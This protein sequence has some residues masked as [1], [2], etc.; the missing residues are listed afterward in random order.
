MTALDIPNLPL[1]LNVLRARP[2]VFQV[3]L[4]GVT[5]YLISCEIVGD[6]A[7]PFGLCHLFFISSLKMGCFLVEGKYLEGRPVEIIY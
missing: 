1:V 6:F 7:L 4:F 5:L 2:V 3:F